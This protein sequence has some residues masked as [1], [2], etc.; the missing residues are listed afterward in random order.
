MFFLIRKQVYIFTF[1]SQISQPLKKNSRRKICVYY[2]CNDRV[3]FLSL[4]QQNR[5]LVLKKSVT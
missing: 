1:N 2:I 5:T 4:S 3:A